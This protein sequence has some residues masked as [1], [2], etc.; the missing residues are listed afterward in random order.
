MPA[1]PIPVSSLGRISNALVPV[2]ALVRTP[3]LE[4]VDGTD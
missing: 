1:E 4:P 2:S 3:Y